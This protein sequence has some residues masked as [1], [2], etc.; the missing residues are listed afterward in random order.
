MELSGGKNLVLERPGSGVWVGRFARPDLRTQLD[1]AGIEDCEL[2]RD[3]SASLL[4]RMADG[5]ALVLNFGLVYRFPTAFYQLLLQ[6]RGALHSRKCRLILCGFVPELLEG[7]Q[8]FKGEKVFDIVH[9]EE[10]AV[11]KALTK[12]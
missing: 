5:D 1:G 4:S 12:G 2:Y 3:L 7:I 6:V 9:T 11:R 8:L 10:Q